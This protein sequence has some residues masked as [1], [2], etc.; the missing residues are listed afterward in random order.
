M[1]VDIENCADVYCDAGYMQYSADGVNWE[2]LG[3]YGEGTNWYTD[4]NYQVWNIQGNTDWRQAEIPL[5][6]GMANVQ[7]R[8][9]L[10]SDQGANYEGMGVDD[11]RIFNK[12]LYVADNNIISISPNPTDNGVVNI[13]WAAHSGTEIKVMMT[14][15]MGK[16]VYGMSAIAQEG[17]NKTTLNTPL[18][19]T[20]MYFMRITIGE[21]EHQHKIIYRQR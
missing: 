19:S 16:D 3:A 17:Y 11:V 14:D 1:F 9:A 5:P 4:S 6:A 21:K 15:M 2:L 13:E 10:H 18:F 8:Y 20:G 7:F 12:K